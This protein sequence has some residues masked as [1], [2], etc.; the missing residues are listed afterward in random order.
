MVAYR[1]MD[2]MRLQEL[3]HASLELDG[4]WETKA[5]GPEEWLHDCL[6]ECCKYARNEGVYE[7]KWTGC[8]NAKRT[9][10]RRWFNECENQNIGLD[11]WWLWLRDGFIGSQPRSDDNSSTAT[12]WFS[13]YVSCGSG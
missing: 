11:E 8:M 4:R 2:A 10:G 3:F 12:Q 7:C 1:S 6:M 9:R 5:R 13:F